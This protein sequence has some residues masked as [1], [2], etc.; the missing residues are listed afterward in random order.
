MGA[1]D[2]MMLSH[3]HWDHAGAR[4]GE[5]LLLSLVGYRLDPVH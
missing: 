1:V 5:S 2:A 4:S 3:G